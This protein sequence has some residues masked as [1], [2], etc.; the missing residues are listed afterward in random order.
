MILTV[1]EISC[2]YLE[3][4]EKVARTTVDFHP[5]LYT[6]ESKYG[7]EPLPNKSVRH[8]KCLGDTTVYDV[9]Y[10]TDAH[11]L[12]NTPLESDGPRT[13]FAVFFGGSITFGMGVE[14]NETLPA[15][16]GEYAPDYAPYNYG[17]PGY[18]PQQM[19]LKLETEDLRKTI[20][21]PT[22]IAVY[23]FIPGHI[24]RAVGSLQPY[25]RWA[26]GF[27]YYKL[28]GDSVQYAGNFR[29][30]RPLLA[31]LYTGLFRSAVVRYFHIDFP[32]IS[33]DYSTTLTAAIIKRSAELFQREFPGSR[34]YVL[35][36]P[37]HFRADK[38]LSQLKDAGVAVLDHQNLYGGV[39][40]GGR[41]EF[42]G[43]PKPESHERV[44]RALSE[45]IEAYRET[46]Q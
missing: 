40:L 7:Y 44:A 26:M 34:F 11:G 29:T 16:F 35:V 41:F 18:G 31:R 10:S 30:G 24:R 15:F 25:N 1:V 27:P 6:Y 45:D 12:R 36:Y 32:P 3:K 21:E 14:D 33:C 17:V 43:H 2:R 46:S 39:L 38:V 28:N 23:T 22:G 42:E 13:R 20:R 9:T 8:V 19:L 5:Q 37:L 4:H